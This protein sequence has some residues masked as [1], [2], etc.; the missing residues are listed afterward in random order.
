VTDEEPPN[1]SQNCLLA[2][3]VFI[4]TNSLVFVFLMTSWH[5]SP[6]STPSYNPR[7][8]A[9]RKLS[10]E[11]SVRLQFLGKDLQASELSVLFSQ[12]YSFSVVSS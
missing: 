10:K 4:G 1:Q 12:Q 8:A 11:I 5:H 2:E 9:L 3:P 6:I 7:G